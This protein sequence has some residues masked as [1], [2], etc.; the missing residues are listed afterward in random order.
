VASV[1]GTR[2]AEYRIDSGA[3]TTGCL[4]ARADLYP[5]LLAVSRVAKNAEPLQFSR[6]Y[7]KLLYSGGVSTPYYILAVNEVNMGGKENE[8]R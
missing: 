8:T 2:D 5:K 6:A 1:I 4:S 7:T 3:R